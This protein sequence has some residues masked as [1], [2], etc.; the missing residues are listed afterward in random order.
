MSISP[1]AGLTPW[2]PVAR[3][4]F[5][6]LRPLEFLLGFG[7][8]PI[9]PTMYLYWADDHLLIARR[10]GTKDRYQR[11]YY[12]D[13]QGLRVQRSGGHHLATLAMLLVGATFAAALGAVY[14]P[15]EEPGALAASGIAGAYFL[16]LAIMN[17][18]AGPLCACTLYTAVEAIPLPGI[19]RWNAGNLFAAELAKRVRAVQGALPAVA[20][21]QVQTAT[22]QRSAN[23]AALRPLNPRWHVLFFALLA[24]VSLLYGGEVLLRANAVDV[25]LPARWAVSIAMGAVVWIGSTAVCAQIGANVPRG[26]RTWT[27]CLLFIQSLLYAGTLYTDFMGGQFALE[28][29]RFAHLAFSAVNAATGLAG[30]A[31]GMIMLRGVRQPA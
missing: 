18:V 11:V 1:T 26:L 27:G 9:A 6:A 14:I 10:N 5:G 7:R 29:M 15:T 19:A 17:E 31:I 28:P 25:P 2:T 3:P 24:L 22:R 12:T 23:A 21:G 20:A 16:V 4:A 30:A 13:A 8:M